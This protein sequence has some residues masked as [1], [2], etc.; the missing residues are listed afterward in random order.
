MDLKS[1][2][3]AAVQRM[4]NLSST[5]PVD[6]LSADQ[7]SD[8]WKVLVFDAAGRDVISPLLNVAQL[9][10]N[11]VTLHMMLDSEREPI[12]DVPAVYFCRPTPENIK[13]IAKDCSDKLYASVHLNF[14]SKLERRLMEDLARQVIEGGAV[15]TIS[16]VRRGR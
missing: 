12:P 4:L 15:S 11:G 6:Q 16:K 10:R 9:R 7:Y 8:Q 13:R 2:Q 14:I 3:Y 1:R 5:S